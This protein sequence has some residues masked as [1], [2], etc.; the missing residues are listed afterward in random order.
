MADG[1]SLVRDGGELGRDEAGVR[2]E[3]VPKP[4]SREGRQLWHSGG[5]YMRVE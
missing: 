1:G 2:S 4:P 5:E 3:G